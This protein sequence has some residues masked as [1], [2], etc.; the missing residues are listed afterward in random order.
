MNV[1]FKTDQTVYLRSEHF[2]GCKLY[3]NSK[4]QNKTKQ[5]T[6]KS[7]IHSTS[8]VWMWEAGEGRRVKT[9]KRVMS[10]EE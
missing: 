1:F 10:G 4:K 7:H 8:Y 9:G 2:T 5:K 6:L 3:L